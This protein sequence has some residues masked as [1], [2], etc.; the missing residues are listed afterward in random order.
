MTRRLTEA[1]VAAALDRVETCLAEERP[2]DAVAD[3]NAVLAAV[4]GHPGA[5]CGVGRVTIQ[6]GDNKTALQVLDMA[7]GAAPDMLEAQN[8]RGV[9]LQN[10]GRLA[11]AE[12]VFRAIVDRVPDNPGAVLNLAS[13]L[14]STGE[15]DRAEALFSR[16]L[17]WRPSD[18]TAGYNLG[19]LHL[20]RGEFAAG[21]MGFELRSSA[22]N[23]GLAQV[24]STQPRWCG[25]EMPGGTLL[26]HAE[27]GL[28]DNIQ[29]VRYATQ[30]GDRVGN[31][32]LEVP[33]ALEVLLAGFP[34][35]TRVIGRDAALPD[36]D[37]HIPVMSL[38]AVFHTDAN[39]IPWPGPYLKADERLI[40]RWR[41]RLE[42]FGDGLHVGLVWAGNPDHRRDS[43]RSIPLATLLP[44]LEVPGVKFHALQ[45]GPAA[46]QLSE[47]GSAGR[48]HHLFQRERPLSDVAAVISAMDLVI[49]VDTSL[50]HLAGALGRPVWTMITKVPDWRWML[51]REDTP[52]YPTMRLFRQTQSGDWQRVVAEVAKAL[53]ERVTS[54]P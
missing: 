49:G 54:G 2:R 23:I 29:F 36:H 10:L 40:G 41:E 37:F 15:F 24:R 18:P 50:V 26:V 53:R 30:A 34:G 6:L 20:V 9:A 5:L 48:I 3:L 14:A 21:W 35:A 12:D 7:L 1:E 28:G 17:E 33:A 45:I 27:Q 38:P 42:R 11:E 13:V 32:I 43:E 8:A 4:P 51:D 22:S 47:I 52:W 44:L 16:V 25:E 19:L 46:T 39:S 31:L